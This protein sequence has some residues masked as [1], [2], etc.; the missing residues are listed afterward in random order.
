MTRAF[1]EALPARWPSPQLLK[2]LRRL[3]KLPRRLLKSKLAMQL[4][5][6]HGWSV[7]RTVAR[8]TSCALGG[9]LLG[10]G[11]SFAKAIKTEL[12]DAEVR[13]ARR[14]LTRRAAR[15]SRVAPRRGARRGRRPRRTQVVHKMG[16][17]LQ[18]SVDVNGTCM[19]KGVTT[20]L[21]GSSAKV[22]KEVAGVARS[23]VA[24]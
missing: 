19:N 16:L 21:G 2:L 5:K 3:P 14:S 10:F 18:F 4:W 20:L 17:P 7:S 22:A 9:H 8:V 11:N 1:D 13:V 23:K 6:T 15:P 24:Q 12:P